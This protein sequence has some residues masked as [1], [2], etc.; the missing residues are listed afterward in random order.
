M[1]N[2]QSMQPDCRKEEGEFCFSYLG[3]REYLMGC[4]S[5][6]EVLPMPFDNFDSALDSLIAPARNCFPITPND[7]ANLVS[8]PKALYIGSG[9]NLV[10]RAVDGTQDVT[11]ANLASGTILD[12]RAL[13]VRATGTTAGNLVG[14]A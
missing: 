9:G 8:L 5:H 10:I 2:A 4:I 1:D 14:L 7:T 13:I 11:F 12:V 6:S 3:I